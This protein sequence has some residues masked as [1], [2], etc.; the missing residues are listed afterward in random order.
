MGCIGKM[1]FAD[2]TEKWM[3]LVGMTKF[4]TPILIKKEKCLNEKGEEGQN[5]W[6]LEMVR[7]TKMENVLIFSEWN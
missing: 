3:S 5:P 7:I 6:T 2:V 1:Q 4:K